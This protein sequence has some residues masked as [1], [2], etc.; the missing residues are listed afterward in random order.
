MEELRQRSPRRFQDLVRIDRAIARARVSTLQM[1][2][3]DVA[4]VLT[5]EDPAALPPARP[6]PSGLRPC[7]AP[8]A[9]PPRADALLG[10][11]ANPEESVRG[12]SG[13]A[14]TPSGCSPG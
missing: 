12:P 8:D 9:L 13:R 3:E 11:W 5:T 4:F 6:L 10:Q 1:L 2:R 7:A 14:C